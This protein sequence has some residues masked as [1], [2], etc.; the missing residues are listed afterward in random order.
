MASNSR[1]S[2]LNI[3]LEDHLANSLRPLLGLLPETLAKELK[4]AL[5]STPGASHTSALCLELPE[6]APVRTISY[7]LL[8]AI[9]KWT[10]TPFAEHA[11]SSHKP[12]L[13]AQ[14]Y[15]MVALLAGTRTSPERTYPL[16]SNPAT[17]DQASQARELGDRRAVTA[18]VN[19]LLSVGG[20]GIATWW[21]A[22]R[23]SCRDEWVSL[24]TLLSSSAYVSPH[25]A[26][27]HCVSRYRTHIWMAHGT[28][29]WISFSRKCCSHCRWRS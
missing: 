22:G 27:D 16:L 28:F 23:L 14:D 20:A 12:P 2:A 13:R 3:S 21:A 29:I 5:E 1:A 15:S 19:A 18:V 11:M 7:A 4:D 17:N 10:R 6:H 24:A 26:D 25:L 9:S 8:T